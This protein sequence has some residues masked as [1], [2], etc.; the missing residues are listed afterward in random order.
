M[1]K[2]VKCKEEK[3]LTEFYKNKISKDGYENNCKI[4]CL[5]I[6]KEYRDINKQKISKRKTEYYKNNTEK[7]KEKTNE[8]RKNNL[9]YYSQYITKY[10]KKEN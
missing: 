1:K 6:N 10:K 8:F 3:E 2:C 9:L 5:K 4:C 7:I